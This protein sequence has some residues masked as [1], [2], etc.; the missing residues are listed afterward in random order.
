M[1]KKYDDLDDKD[2]E[3]K[4]FEADGQ[5]IHYKTSQV[6]PVQ[7]DFI[8]L[9]EK[10]KEFINYC[11]GDADDL[12]NILNKNISYY[13]AKDLDELLRRW[14]NKEYDFKYFDEN[15]FVNAI[16]AAFGNYLNKEFNTIWSLITDEYGT[17]YACIATGE[18]QFQ[19][20]PF[21]MEGNRT[22]KR[23]VIERYCPDCK[24]E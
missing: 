20:F 3:D 1:A 23:R 11:L 6:E 10:E 4:S 18:H 24:K 9:N 22:K 5:T 16:G 17:D 12:L 21:G 15:Q 7:Q 19:L 8:N 14:N 2:Y 13:S